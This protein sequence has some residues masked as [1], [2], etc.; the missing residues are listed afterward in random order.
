[1]TAAILTMTGD[2]AY[3]LIFPEHLAMLPVMD[4]VSMHHAMKQS[5][6]VWVGYDGPFVLCSWGLIPP[7]ILSD[8]AYLWLWTTE[9]LHEHVF[10]FIRYSQREIG[11]MLEHFPI[12]VGHAK[13]D[14]PKS[15]RWLRWLGATFGQ[16]EGQLVPFEIR[17]KAI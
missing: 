12:I 8:R 1:M 16:P 4:Q 7:T 3:D 9:H 17:A 11:R 10:M 15:I 5:S 6:K 2:E 13:V 14:T